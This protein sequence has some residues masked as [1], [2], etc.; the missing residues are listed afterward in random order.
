MLLYFYLFF[1]FTT[2]SPVSRVMS[3][4]GWHSIFNYL[5]NEWWVNGWMSGWVDGWEPY[6]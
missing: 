3:G 1:S 4:A 6:N 2:I 5:L